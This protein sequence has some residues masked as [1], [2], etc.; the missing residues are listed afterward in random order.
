MNAARALSPRSSRT[1]SAVPS[2]VFTTR[3]AGELHVTS[4]AP[5]VASVTVVN[6]SSEVMS[7][8]TEAPPTDAVTSLMVCTY[9]RS[10]TRSS[11]VSNFCDSCGGTAP[12][13]V[14]TWL[15]LECSVG[16]Q[17]GVDDEF[18]AVPSAYAGSARGR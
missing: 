14:I 4:V 15:T 3:L 11:R 18:E 8:V 16:V 1:R 13:N 7:G 12:P 17:V 9:W 6:R 10:P 2:P 5:L